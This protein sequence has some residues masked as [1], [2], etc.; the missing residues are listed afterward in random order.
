MAGSLIDVDVNVKHSPCRR[1]ERAKHSL[2]ELRSRK[3]RQPG[4]A[5]VIPNLRTTD[6][7]DAPRR[8]ARPR[9]VRSRR[10]RL[11][12][13]G[14]AAEGDDLFAESPGSGAEG[15]AEAAALRAQGAG[16][17]QEVPGRR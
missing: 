15:P 8:G 5:A 10:P 3:R 14:A 9:R 2:E 4:R 7:E 12:A 11:H 16:S 17:G 6:E 13:P 1:Q